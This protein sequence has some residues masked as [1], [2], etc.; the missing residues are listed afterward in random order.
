MQGNQLPLRYLSVTING[1]ATSP[2]IDLS[3]LTLVGI[4]TPASISGTSMTF[5]GANS[6]GGTYTAIKDKAGSDYTL[7]ITSSKRYILPPADTAG[8]EFIKLVSSTS[9]TSK[10]FTLICRQLA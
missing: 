3:G 4:E 9:E 8:W 10:T 5:T 6:L 1:S 2:A 7:T